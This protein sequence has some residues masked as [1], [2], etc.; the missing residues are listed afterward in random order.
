MPQKRAL[1]REKTSKA[2]L[3][4]KSMTK[5]E[6]AR[7]VY[8]TTQL[9]LSDSQAAVQATFESIVK[10]LV[11]YGRVE[12]RGFGVFMIQNRSARRARNPRTG[13]EVWVDEHETVVFK[14]S[15]LMKTNIQEKRSKRA[16]AKK[17]RKATEAPVKSAKKTVKKVATRTTTAAKRS[18]RRGR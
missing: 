3:E 15:R 1:W 9:N 8:N 14:P 10:L 4:R 6:I 5:K 18:P 13:E 11:K 16:K 17:A 12:L 2:T 7:L